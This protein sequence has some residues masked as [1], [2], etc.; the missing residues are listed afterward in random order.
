[1]VVHDLHYYFQ[2]S[3]CT[4]LKSPIIFMDFK[5]LMQYLKHKLEFDILIDNFG[6][7]NIHRQLSSETHSIFFII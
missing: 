6:F 4:E 3:N 1:M 2:I 5:I 7:I